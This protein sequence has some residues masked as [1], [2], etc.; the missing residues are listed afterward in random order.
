VNPNAT[1]MI[2]TS[3]A[4]FLP[5]RDPQSRNVENAAGWLFHSIPYK[6]LP[7][8]ALLL[9]IPHAMPLFPFVQLHRRSPLRAVRWAV[10]FEDLGS[11][12]WAAEFL[13]CLFLFLFVNE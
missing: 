8:S 10:R 1:R 5:R 3:P 4:S 2:V 12:L 9:S 13:F 11:L 7:R 6:V